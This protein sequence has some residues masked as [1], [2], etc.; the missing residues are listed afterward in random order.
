MIWKALDKYSDLGLLVLRLGL[1]F[2]FFFYH[3][4]D[5]ITGGPE[6]WHGLGSALSQLG[7]TFWPTFWGFMISFAESF[8]ALFIAVGFLVRPMSVIL[9]IGMFVAWYTHVASGNGNPAHAFKN[10]FVL[11]GL[12]VIGPGKY[13]IDAWIERR[14]SAEIES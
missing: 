4:F 7:I 13:S 8:G 11:L 1:G 14:R 12:F 3:G 2:G 5:K 9:A 6:R 10:F